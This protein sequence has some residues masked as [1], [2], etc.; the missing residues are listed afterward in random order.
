MV[1][2]ISGEVRW[3]EESEALAEGVVA[4]P[5]G[6]PYPVTVARLGLA[7]LAVQRGDVAGAT[8]QYS[9]LKDAPRMALLFISTD[10]VLG[11]LCLTMGLLDKAEAHF[12]DALAFCRKAGYRPELAWSLCEYADTLLERK[13][14][15]DR[16]K[17]MSLLDASMKISG[18]LKMKPLMERV[19][20]K[21]E[22]LKA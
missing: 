15:G 5:G 22:F 1:A 6:F 20:S 10:R 9:V 3:A 17:A 13:G 2:R 21:R 19:L 8:D 18:E 12:E 14:T 7:L 11:L 4:V 16:A